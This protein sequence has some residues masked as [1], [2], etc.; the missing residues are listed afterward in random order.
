LYFRGEKIPPTFTLDALTA[1]SSPSPTVV[2]A[3]HLIARLLSGPCRLRIVTGLHLIARL[4]SGPC[5][6]R[7]VA[8]RR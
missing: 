7:I 5:R 4:L 8:G 3:L 1:H 6:L 2:T